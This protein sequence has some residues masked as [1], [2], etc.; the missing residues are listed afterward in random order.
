MSTLAPPVAR[1]CVVETPLTR[2]R[3]FG[4]HTATPALCVLTG[5]LRTVP[6]ADPG[7]RVLQQL[8]AALTTDGTVR[9]DQFA[10]AYA[11]DSCGA[12][13]SIESDLDRVSF[14]ARAC[15]ADLV[16]VVELLAECLREPRFDAASLETERARLLAEC[17]YAAAE[18][19]VLAGDALS[20][21]IY[22]PEHPRH[23]SEIDQRIAH[24]ERFTLADVRRYH[25]EHFGADDLCLVA[26][27]DIDP[28]A[29]AAEC[30]RRFASW[31][32][33]PPR[34]GGDS[35]PMDGAV[36]EVRIAAP[37]RE[38]FDV[39]LGQRLALRCDDPDYSA[40]WIANHMLGGTF[41][42]RLVAAVRERRGLTYS[43]RSTLA[44]PS[45]VFDGH[46][47]VDVALSPDKLDAGLAATR[48]E[49]QRFVDDGVCDEELVSAR[50]E[51]VGTFRI[52]LATLSG[53]GEAV[54]FGAE[55]GWGAGYLR[56]FPAMIEDVRVDQINRVLRGQLRPAQL[57]TAIAGPFDDT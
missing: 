11:L 26:V 54:L 52:G 4:L 39:A 49:I 40:L 50:R 36:R 38:N 7:E 13:L 17:R 33:C 55:R 16:L 3:F 47:Q 29:V 10:I 20:R 1:E 2:G 56:E 48:E 15:T 28:L 45:R 42:S 43:I 24:L 53:L 57:H 46:W 30:D 35:G 12:S 27:G 44:K 8:V 37:G 34:R 23:Q 19:A 21:L 41:T 22:A 6:A 5:S 32:P 51:A 31:S 18:P 14:S 9:R 25:R